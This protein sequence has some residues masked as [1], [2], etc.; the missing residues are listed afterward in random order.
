MSSSV[1]DRLPTGHLG[2]GHRPLAPGRAQTLEEG[3]RG[4][5]RLGGGRRN[6]GS[7]EGRRKPGR[8]QEGDDASRE[9]NEREDTSR[10]RG[11]RRTKSPAME[12]LVGEDKAAAV[13]YGKN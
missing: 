13:C 6:R 7:Q 12:D 2:G 5:S 10:P 9:L 11:D 3:A 1:C 4:V 8:R